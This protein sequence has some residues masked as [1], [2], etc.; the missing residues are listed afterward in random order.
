MKP[1]LFFCL[2]VILTAPLCA[3]Q[4]CPCCTE[5]HTQFDCWVGD[6]MVLDTLGNS[7]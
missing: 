2:L 1:Q 7:R 6:W 3:Q 5:K 4:E